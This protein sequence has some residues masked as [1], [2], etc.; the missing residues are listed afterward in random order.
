LLEAVVFEKGGTVVAL[1]HLHDDFLVGWKE[2]CFPRIDVSTLADPLPQV[3]LAENLLS[4]S[5]TR[6][7]G[8]EVIEFD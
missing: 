3:S 5:R 8:T 7:Q 1:V 2:V 4:V 6:H